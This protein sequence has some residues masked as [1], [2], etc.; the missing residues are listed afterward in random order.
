MRVSN[1]NYST[2]RVAKN[3][4][5]GMALHMPPKA[6]IE[7]KIGRYAADE[8]ESIKPALEE[9]ARS[10]HI[11]G[12]P[13]KGK[14]ITFDKLIL[15]VQNETT[16]L[17]INEHLENPVAEIAVYPHRGDL[18]PCF[19]DDVMKALQIAQDMLKALPR[20]FI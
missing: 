1:V 10:L 14:D 3:Q 4:N 19:S 15:R 20:L 6:E 11:S 7:A 2:N 16:G 8:I 18:R 12:V 5:F 17:I 13:E 9:A